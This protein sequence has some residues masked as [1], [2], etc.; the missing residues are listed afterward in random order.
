MLD[1]KRVMFDLADRDIE[2]IKISP[3]IILLVL[4][5]GGGDLGAHHPLRILSIETGEAR[6]P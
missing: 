5:R 4:K 6:P 1:P 3:G 2:E